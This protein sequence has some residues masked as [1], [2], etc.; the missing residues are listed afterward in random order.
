MAPEFQV[1][2]LAGSRS[3]FGLPSPPGN[4]RKMPVG[5]FQILK[6]VK[7]TAVATVDAKCIPKIITT[8]RELGSIGNFYQFEYLHHSVGDPYGI[9]LFRYFQ[10]G[11]G[12]C[13]KLDNADIDGMETPH[14]PVDWVFSQK[15]SAPVVPTGKTPKR[16][17]RLRVISEI[18]NIEL[19][20]NERISFDEDLILK[21]YLKN[22]EKPQDSDK[23]STAIAECFDQNE[24]QCLLTNFPDIKMRWASSSQGFGMKTN[25]TL[26]KFTEQHRH[27]LMKLFEEGASTNNKYTPEEAVNIMRGKRDEH[28]Q[29]V[30]SIEEILIESQIKSFWSRCK[31]SQSKGS[32][33][34]SQPASQE[35]Q[36]SQEHIPNNFSGADANDYEDDLEESIITNFE[37]LTD[38]I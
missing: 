35:V 29:K 15:E 10:I 6:G 36:S 9:R 4:A 20:K 37:D 8:G 17:P 1:V 32:Q 38:L 22:M 30:F 24:S 3:F 5:A 21:L 28:G 27:F 34:Q 26:A 13:V 19:D 31:A 16:H 14:G 2:S 18:P 7:N 12:Q 23:K 25:R 33:S 11:P